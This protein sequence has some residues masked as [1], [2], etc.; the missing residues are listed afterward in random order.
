[1]VSPAAALSLGGRARQTRHRRAVIWLDHRS[2]CRQTGRIKIDAVASRRW[3]ARRRSAFLEQALGQVKG[4][5]KEAGVSPAVQRSQRLGQM[6]RCA[7]HHAAG[8]CRVAFTLR[9]STSETGRP[10][11]EPATDIV[12]GQ[13]LTEWEVW[14]GA[15]SLSRHCSL[16][17]LFGPGNGSIF[18]E[19][20]MKDMEDWYNYAT[21][22]VSQPLSRG[23]R[24]QHPHSRTALGVCADTA[25]LAQEAFHSCA[26]TPGTN[27]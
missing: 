11:S 4:R 8:V 15:A 27:S 14:A 22:L 20:K 26:S 3:T 23:Q 7:D 10:Q 19:R 12:F 9:L 5:T 24:Q 25:G 13:R 18:S 2:R 17:S 1:M 6:E 16:R 21:A